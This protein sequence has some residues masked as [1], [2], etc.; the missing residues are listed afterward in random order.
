MSKFFVNWSLRTILNIKFVQTLGSRS[1][2]K[3]SVFCYVFIFNFR[4]RAY[5]SFLTPKTVIG[6]SKT[7]IVFSEAILLYLRIEKCFIVTTL[8]DNYDFVFNMRI[9]STRESEK[10]ELLHFRFSIITT[11]ECI[12]GNNDAFS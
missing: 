2:K 9:P 4:N 1:G 6:N 3:T 7:Q 10:P 12:S 8:K 5:I 11:Y